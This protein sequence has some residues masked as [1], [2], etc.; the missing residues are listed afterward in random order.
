V[1]AGRKL[2]GSAQRRSAHALLQQ[3]SVLLGEGH[4]RLADYLPGTPEQRDEARAALARAAAH[5]GAWLPGPPGLERWAEA[6]AAELPEPPRRIDAEAGL[7]LIET[8]LSAS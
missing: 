7:I 8:A 2:V 3:G 6:I 4:L 5:A 1:L